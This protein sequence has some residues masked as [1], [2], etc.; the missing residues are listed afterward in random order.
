MAFDLGDSLLQIIISHQFIWNIRNFDEALAQSPTCQFI[1][2]DRAVQLNRIGAVINW[3]LL[4]V[5]Q[6]SA[7]GK[8]SQLYSSRITLMNSV[9]DSLAKILNERTDWFGIW[10]LF[11][12]TF[13]DS[14]PKDITLSYGFFL[15]RNHVIRIL[16]TNRQHLI[17]I[18]GIIRGIVLTIN[19]LEYWWLGHGLAYGFDGFT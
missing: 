4:D 17:S 3:S 8:F 19:S 15:G 1:I 18:V 5:I 16:T 11:F 13:H 12:S 14:F 6:L 9:P 7:S 2:T 10:T